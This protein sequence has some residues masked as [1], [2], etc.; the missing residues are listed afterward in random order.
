MSTRPSFKDHFS[1]DSKAYRTYR[2]TY[3][4]ALFSYLATVAQKNERA[5]DCAT[6]N[7][8][9][10]V[11]L[12]NH[13]E[14][15]VATDASSQQIDEAQ[16]RSNIE[17]VVAR[18]EQVPIET[19]SIDLVTV[20]QALH[21]FNVDA[22]FL[23]TDRVLKSEGVLAVW[24]YNMLRIEPAIDAIVHRFAYETVGP[25]WPE[26]RAIV[27]ANY[28]SIEFPYTEVDTPVFEM[29][30][31]WNLEELLA[32]LGTWSGVKRYRE[33]ESSDPVVDVEQALR[34]VWRGGKKPMKWPFS[35]FVR[36]KV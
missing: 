25:Y 17:Y 19:G 36:R 2:P 16:V 33:V 3:P 31:E 13:F 12:S 21:W 9:A 27:D 23:E 22:F 30:I 15:V 14:W 8:Q 24:S 29:E 7:G 35:L 5:W 10:A 32:Y 28:Q 6:G 34:A 1:S 26:E 4:A 20:A 11:E 18:A